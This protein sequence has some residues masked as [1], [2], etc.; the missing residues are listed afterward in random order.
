[1]QDANIL[2]EK[3]LDQFM[4]ELDSLV[5]LEKVKE[6]VKNIIAYQKY[7]DLREE[8]G[9]PS[10]SP[11]LRM[12]FLGNS[13]TGKTTVARLIGELYKAF[14]ILSQGHIIMARREDLVSPYVGM[15]EPKTR[16]V[17]EK[18]HGGVL[19][20]DAGF[21]KNASDTFGIEA[22]KTLGPYMI[23]PQ[24]DFLL[25]I[26][27]NQD[28]I[29]TFMSVDDTLPLRFN[30]FYFDDYSMD[31]LMQILD[32]MVEKSGYKMDATT[33]DY[34]KGII[35]KDK[36]MSGSSFGNARYICSLCEKAIRNFENR[37]TENH[38]SS[39]EE[40]KVFIPSDFQSL[41]DT[42]HNDIAKSKTAEQLLEEL[43]QFAGM[44]KIKK[45]VRQLINQTNTDLTLADSG[46]D[47][48]IF[49]GN[50]E[51][52]KTTFARS[53]GELYKSARLL[54]TGQLVVTD[55]DD[56]VGSYIGQTAQKTQK[57]LESARGGVLFIDEAYT[58][59]TSSSDSFG[60][61]A[62]TAILAYMV[63]HHGE[64]VVILAGY[65]DKMN[66]FIQEFPLL[67]SRFTTII[68]FEQ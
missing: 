63:K 25:I 9:L 41:A 24:N 19:V 67:K 11:N 53:I 27:G 8:H 29:E 42:N 32:N 35:E 40:A 58:L 64:L 5:G 51:S 26:E 34:V 21:W 6:K 54:P 23:N 4:E 52:G 47:A 57:I 3:A 7:T 13:G 16:S 30:F 43:D 62:V 20:I 65:P 45:Q 37:T 31:E 56:L 22:L 44:E 38:D 55:R 61:E 28:E 1:M 39:T 66:K 18:A 50:P 33:R 48:L 12:V 59:V 60:I 15:A 46:I 68:S 49:T 10:E 14:G 17:I 2:K 36:R